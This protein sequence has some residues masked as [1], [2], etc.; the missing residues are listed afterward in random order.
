METLSLTW[1]IGVIEV[2]VLSTL[3]WQMWQHRKQLDT[4]IDHLTER[5]DKQR[6][7]WSE[8]L[9]AYKLE[10]A[11]TYAS[12]QS[13][14]EVEGRLVSHLSRIE[15]KLDHDAYRARGYKNWENSDS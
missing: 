13:L 4:K 5:L 14:R 11:K 6:V 2:P 9:A 10:V 7:M 15:A 3:F 8:G 1:W 12:H